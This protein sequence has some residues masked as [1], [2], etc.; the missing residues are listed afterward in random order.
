MELVSGLKVTFSLSSPVISK[1]ISL[2][3]GFEIVRVA[4][5]L[6]SS[7]SSIDG[8]TAKSISGAPTPSSA[9]VS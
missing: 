4:I 5:A 2:L 1:F 7:F 6:F 8:A 3:P 9:A